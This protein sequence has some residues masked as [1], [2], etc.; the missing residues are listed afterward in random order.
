[1]DAIGWWRQGSGKDGLLAAVTKK[2]KVTLLPCMLPLPWL[3]L[4]SR[5]SQQ[6]NT[7]LAHLLAQHR[8]GSCAAPR[9]LIYS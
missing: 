7:A 5:H 8:E 9:K 4:H 2:V 1:M 6:L 3:L